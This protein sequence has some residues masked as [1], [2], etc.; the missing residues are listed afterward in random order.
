MYIN[1]NWIS[2]SVFL[3]DWLERIMWEFFHW[4]KFSMSWSGWWFHWVCICQNSLKLYLSQKCAKQNC[5][6]LRKTFLG[7]ITQLNLGIIYTHCSICLFLISLITVRI[8]HLFV[9]L[10]DSHL[11]QFLNFQEEET[12][13]NLFT[14][15]S[16]VPNT[17]F[18]IHGVFSD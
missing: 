17:V 12:V 5:P 15:E 10:F 3:G 13:T 11:S 2:F 9:Q 7:S 14:T 8:L 4:W 6:L 18:A 16:P 1:R